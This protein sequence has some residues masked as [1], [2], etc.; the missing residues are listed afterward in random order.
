MKCPI[1]YEPG[2]WGLVNVPERDLERPTLT[3]AFSTHLEQLRIPGSKS[4]EPMPWFETRTFTRLDLVSK[5]RL[6]YH[7]YI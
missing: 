6:M 5:D 1:M 7:V 3:L 4:L 2:K